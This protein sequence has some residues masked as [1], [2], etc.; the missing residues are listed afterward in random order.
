MT[1]LNNIN[2]DRCNKSVINRIYNDKCEYKKCFITEV[3]IGLIISAIIII[4]INII[5]LKSNDIL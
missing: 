3:I 4:I 1:S 2:T 5:M